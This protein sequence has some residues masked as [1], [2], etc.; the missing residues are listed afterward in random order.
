MN[1]FET[2]L[3]VRLIAL[4]GM[5]LIKYMLIL[6][7]ICVQTYETRKRLEYTCH[8]GFFVSI[9]IVQWA[10]LLICKTRTNSLFQQGM[11]LVTY[12]LHLLIIVGQ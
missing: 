8:A 11:K 9:V 10:D 12:S 6:F 4:I 1:I 3:H 7:C 5:Q 2:C